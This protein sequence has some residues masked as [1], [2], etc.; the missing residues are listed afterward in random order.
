MDANEWTFQT[1]DRCNSV[2]SWNN[3]TDLF[4]NIVDFNVM[5]YKKYYS[6]LPQVLGS[7][8]NGN[9]IERN[10]FLDMHFEKLQLEL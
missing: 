6:D 3:V 2:C 8:Q 7:R 4:A 1:E 5:R 10:T 9:S